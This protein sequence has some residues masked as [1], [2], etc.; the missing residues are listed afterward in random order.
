M[1]RLLVGELWCEGRLP[2][3]VAALWQSTAWLCLPPHLLSLPSLNC[4]FRQRFAALGYPSFHGS[5]SSFLC[6]VSWEFLF[7]GSFVCLPTSLPW[8]AVQELLSPWAAF[9]SLLPGFRG[10]L[11]H[12]FGLL[13]MTSVCHQS[14]TPCLLCIPA[15]PHSRLLRQIRAAFLWMFPALLGSGFGN[16][17]VN[18]TYQ[19]YFTKSWAFSQPCLSGWCLGGG[20]DPTITQPWTRLI[21]P[22]DPSTDLGQ[23]A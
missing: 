9:P 20:P 6:S 7:L 2:A 21:A 23:C 19:C 4:A 15:A 8:N 5:E 11:C 22:A 3:A 16:G 1:A 17:F 18:Q 12:C 10:H 13:V 14:Y